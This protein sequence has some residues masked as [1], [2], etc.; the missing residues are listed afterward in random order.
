[1]KKLLL[2][3]LLCLPMAAEAQVIETFYTQDFKLD[4]LR[5]DMFRADYDY[6]TINA[7]AYSNGAF[8]MGAVSGASSK[9]WT[10]YYSEECA[11][12]P[13]RYTKSG[14]TDNWLVTPAIELPDVDNLAFV[15][16]AR[17]LSTDTPDGYRI[18][19]ST[20]GQDKEDFT[21]EPLVTVDAEA[22]S[23]T[24]HYTSL[25]AYRGR[26]VYVA[27]HHNTEGLAILIDNIRAVQLEQM[28]DAITLENL[29]PQFVSDRNEQL[30]LEGRLTTE[31]GTV[32]TDADIAVEYDGGNWEG[33]ITSFTPSSDGKSVTFRQQVPV[34]V[35]SSG[36]LS[37]SYTVTVG[38]MVATCSGEVYNP[39]P[40]IYDRRIV[41]EERTGTW[42]PY[43]IRGLAAID[44]AK[45][46]YPDNYIGIAVHNQD[47]MTD[48]YY[49]GAIAAYCDA[50]YPAAVV[51]RVTPISPF[52]QTFLDAISN[53]LRDLPIAGVVVR[54]DWSDETRQEID[55][56]VYANFTFSADDGHFNVALVVIEQDVHQPDNDA[57]AQRNGYAYGSMGA[58]GGYEKYGNPIPASEMHYSDVA[59]GIF[60][61]IDGAQAFGQFKANSPALYSS[62]IQLPESV[63]EKDN[64]EVAALLI[65]PATGEILNAALVAAADFGNM[66]DPG[67]GVEDGTQVAKAAAYCADGN[68]IVD[69]SGLDGEVDVTVYGLGGQQLMH[70]TLQGG[71]LHDLGQLQ[72]SGLCVVAVRGDDFFE[73]YK[74]MY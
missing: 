12:A 37:Y 15:W 60:P 68:I 58:M 42:C 71:S 67:L 35:P 70:K 43:C 34:T 57:Y 6:L 3:G 21:D 36:K 74:L 69:L 19:V 33:K 66:D 18:M 44:A 48:S 32:I 64:I 11:V 30:V 22:G 56:N 54:A 10:I 39:G 41:I 50:G 9:G 72:G 14:T 65:D 31:F 29:T 13:S 61:D 8:A 53:G 73:T 20:T 55:V 27:V 5:N 7:A 45:E 59:R 51:N 38:D 24:T 1:M 17:S 28:S 40:S 2:F 47:V 46:R 4:F 63:I 23:W 49:D 16:D 26:T 25:D 52:P 62:T